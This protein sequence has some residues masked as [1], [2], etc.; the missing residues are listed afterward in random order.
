MIFGCPKYIKALYN[1]VYDY[2]LLDDFFETFKKN[3]LDYWIDFPFLLFV[4][5]LK[6]L[7]RNNKID[8]PEKDWSSN[9]GRTVVDDE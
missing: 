5:F 7:E 9:T 6:I 2:N 3:I 8:R 4:K 1:S